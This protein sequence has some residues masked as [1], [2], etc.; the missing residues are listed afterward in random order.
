MSILYT[1]T[2]NTIG[3]LPSYNIT[4]T[5]K[6]TKTN[7]SSYRYFVNWLE[8]YLSVVVSNKISSSFF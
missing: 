4:S 1:F 3:P 6:Y 5:T 8:K 2:K 7:H